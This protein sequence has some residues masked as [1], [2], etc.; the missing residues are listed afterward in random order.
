MARWQL[1]MA[2]LI[3]CEHWT[4]PWPADS[5]PSFSISTTQRKVA[6]TYSRTRHFILSCSIQY[7]YIICDPDPVC[8][9]YIARIFCVKLQ[10]PSSNLYIFNYPVCYIVSSVWLSFLSHRNTNVCIERYRAYKYCT[11]FNASPAGR[12]GGTSPI[13]QL[14]SPIITRRTRTFST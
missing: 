10:F 13:L 9:Y 14:P 6:N 5:S 11:M 4:V 3:T 12:D 1:A 2:T 8:P 7:K